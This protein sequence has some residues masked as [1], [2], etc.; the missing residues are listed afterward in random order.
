[1]TGNSSMPTMWKTE[2]FVEVILKA[3]FGGIVNCSGN[4][5]EK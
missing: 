3:E 5:L 1:M 4:N 2:M